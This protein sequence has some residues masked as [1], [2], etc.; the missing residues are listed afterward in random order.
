MARN[1]D[2]AHPDE[3][4]AMVARLECPGFQSY[5]SKFPGASL[6]KEDHI[7]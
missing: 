5:A 1:M 4:E 3:D 2:D 7:T 6:L